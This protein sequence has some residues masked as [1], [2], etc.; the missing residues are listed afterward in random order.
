MQRNFHRSILFILFYFIWV[1][2]VWYMYTF[3]QLCAYVTEGA[4]VCVYS[5]THGRQ[6]LT[7]SVFLDC[8][9][10]C[11][12][13]QDLLFNLELINLFSW[14]ISSRE[15]TCLH[16]SNLMVRLQTCAK[17]HSVYIGDVHLHLGNMSEHH[18]IYLLGHCPSPLIPFLMQL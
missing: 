7:S 10:S 3:M 1:M 9:L 16:P 2:C 11:L 15:C 14:Q 8:S 6:M 5:H 18:I 4:Y 12:L 13:R 17:I